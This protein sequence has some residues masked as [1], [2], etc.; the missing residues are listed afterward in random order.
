M[1]LAMEH[2]QGRL[3]VIYIPSGFSCKWEVA[4]AGSRP[5]MD[6]GAC[7]Y[8]YVEKIGKKLQ[9]EAAGAAAEKPAEGPA[10][11]TPAAGGVEKTGGGGVEKPGGGAG[12]GAKDP[13]KFG[14]DAP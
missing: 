14:E 3:G 11:D 2:G 13:D 12:G 5:L 9:G 7:I 10:A 8:L 6:V 1:G 4:G